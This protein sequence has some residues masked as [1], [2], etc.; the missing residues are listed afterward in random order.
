MK[1]ALLSVLLSLTGICRSQDTITVYSKQWAG[2]ICCSTGNDF[3]VNFPIQKMSMNVDSVDL[4]VNGLKIR[5]PGNLLMNQTPLCSFSFGWT[6][7]GHYGD[8]STT[9]YGIRADQ[10]TV[11]GILE[12]RAVFYYSDGTKKEPFIN[13][14]EEYL[15]YP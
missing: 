4:F 5:F 2:G 7:V 13:L 12:N 10:I 6:Q 9:Y 3:T 15:A 1:I 8:P 14:R 11:S